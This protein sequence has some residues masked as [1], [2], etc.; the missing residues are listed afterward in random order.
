M[1][2]FKRFSI[3][4]DRCALKVGTDGVILGAWT[5]VEGAKRVL[6]IGTGTGLLALM[7]AQRNDQAQIDA[8]E[9]DD[10]SAEQAA[11]NVAASPWSDR[12]RV[13]RMDVRK[14]KSDQGYDLIICNPPFYAGEMRSPDERTGLAKH[15]GELSFADLTR[16]V[17]DHLSDDGR[18]ACIIPINREKELID[19]LACFGI[20]PSRRCE[21]KY[22]E[23]RPAK[24]LLLEF[25]RDRKEVRAEVLV[26]EN[27]PG[28]FT[29][30]Y[31]YLLKDFLLKF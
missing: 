24:R 13:H 31:R 1:F 11:E 16:T 2:H 7:I 19:L 9:I 14:M 23:D 22:L 10:A 3:K 27:A 12:I 18:F 4:Q 21:L 20:H 26:V 5:N 29:L 8:I 25:S 30:Q 15:S 6:D 17:S 28:E